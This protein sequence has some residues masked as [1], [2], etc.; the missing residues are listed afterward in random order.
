MGTNENSKN[1][2]ISHGTTSK[3]RKNYRECTKKER[4]WIGPF[5]RKPKRVNKNGKIGQKIWAN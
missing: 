1:I 5:I 4:E 2:L 3:E